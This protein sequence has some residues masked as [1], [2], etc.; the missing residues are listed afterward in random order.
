MQEISPS[1]GSNGAKTHTLI[2]NVHGTFA[3]DSEWIKPNSEFSASIQ[4]SSLRE[5]RIQAFRWSGKNSGEERA[6]AARSLT[7]T[8]LSAGTPE[9]IVIGHSHGG[10]IARIVAR[11]IPDKVVICCISTPFIYTKLI[12]RKINVNIATAFY[13]YFCCLSMIL[14]ALKFETI[15]RDQFGELK[16]GLFTII[17]A[18]FTILKFIE[19]FM[20]AQARKMRRLTPDCTN[21]KFICSIIIHGDEA[22]DIL[23]SIRF[24]PYIIRKQLHSLTF[25]LVE[26]LN[27]LCDILDFGD[28]RFYKDLLKEGDLSRDSILKVHNRRN[29]QRSLTYRRAAAL[30]MAFALLPLRLEPYSSALFLSVSALI[31]SIAL[32]T[33]IAYIMYMVLGIVYGLAHLGFGLDFVLCGHFI[34]IDVEPIPIG[35]HRTLSFKSENVRTLAHSEG[36]MRR[37][38]ANV[39][40]KLF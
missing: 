34:K 28:F 22:I 10:N 14:M 23:R 30:C 16:I 20:R 17:F 25:V 26:A 19:N 2:C 29:H 3:K 31:T 37:D 18:S 11:K 27:R 6:K 38:I 8:I 35:R 32:I 12:S 5:T 24:I 7:E 40:G 39:I 15:S 9:C 1:D 21:V 33:F 4:E 13:A 36:Y